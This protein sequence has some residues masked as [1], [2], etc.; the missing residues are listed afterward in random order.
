[1]Q[2]RGGQMNWVPSV[3]VC[4][5][6]LTTGG[7][8]FQYLRRKESDPSDIKVHVQPTERIASFD[9][10]ASLEMRLDNRSSFKAWLEEAKLVI[11]GLDANFQTAVAVGQTTHYI[12]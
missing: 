6:T 11:T 12:R 8:I 7:M 1:M 2:F 4:G 3:V 9:V 10:W 5:L